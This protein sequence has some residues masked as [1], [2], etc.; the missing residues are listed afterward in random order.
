MESKENILQKFIDQ[1]PAGRLVSLED[2]TGV[3]AFLCTP[4]AKMII[5]QTIHV[6]GGY[7]LKISK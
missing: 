3:V 5:G 2:V 6:D 1:V 4:A 7:M